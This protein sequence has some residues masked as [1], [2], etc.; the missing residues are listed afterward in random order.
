MLFLP[1][2]YGF[3][4][5]ESLP[6]LTVSRIMQVI[7]YIYVIINHKRSFLIKLSDIKIISREYI[8]LTFYYVFRIIS[9]LYY[10]ATYSDAAK[11]IFSIIIEQL[12][13]LYALYLLKLSSKEIDTLLKFIAWSATALFAIGIFESLTSIRPFDTLYTVSRYMYNDYYVRLGLLRATTTFGL[14]N[15]YG[16]MCVLITPIIFYL[17]KTTRKKIYIAC[18]LLDILAIIHSG[19]RSDMIFFIALYTLFLVFVS[20]KSKE[21]VHII[22]DTVLIISILFTWIVLTSLIS[23]NF[24]YYYEGTA[25]SILNAVGFEFNLNEGAPAGV[26]GYGLN[27]INPIHSRTGQLSA[28]PYTL[29][30]N[31]IFG[32]GSGCQNRGQVMFYNNTTWIY[33]RTL[34]IGIVEIICTEGILGLLGYISLFLCL[35]IV[36]K[37]KLLNKN[38]PVAFTQLT[39]FLVIS[40][41]LCILS[42]VNMPSYLT[43]IIAIAFYNNKFTKFSLH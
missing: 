5:S 9:N 28:I 36:I 1:N 14:A 25:K 32:L 42:T 43:L 6:L 31:P 22:R 41:F 16:N 11:T 26:A 39:C 8:F 40:Y 29:S 7:F 12:M 17:Y 3:E 37:E 34:D 4:F 23:P 15:F 18:I 13:L 19:C 27:E 21:R 35:L 38:K 2:Y 24:H 33:V 20:N 30:V 10:V